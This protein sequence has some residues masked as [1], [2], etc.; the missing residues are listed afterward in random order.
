MLQVNYVYV[1]FVVTLV[2]M[3]P[4]RSLCMAMT[5]VSYLCLRDPDL[6]IPEPWDRLREPALQFLYPFV[7]VLLALLTS[8]GVR[9]ISGLICGIIVAL[10]HAALHRSPSE[11]RYIR[12]RGIVRWLR[13]R[14]APVEGI[15]PLWRDAMQHLETWMAEMQLRLQWKLLRFREF[16]GLLRLTLKQRFYRKVPK[17][18]CLWS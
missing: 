13:R 7:S 17:K 11:M 10:L 14:R 15:R 1:V 4:V 8:L 6:T 2:V 9:L 12:Q 5:L 18:A 16:V 3:G